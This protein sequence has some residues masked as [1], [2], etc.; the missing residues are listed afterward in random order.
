MVHNPGRVI[1]LLPKKL[2]ALFRSDVEGFYFSMGMMSGL[3]G[4][5]QALYVCLRGFAELYYIVL[6]VL[7]AIALPRVLPGPIQP[8]HIG[9]AVIVGLALVYLVLFG[10]SRYHFPMMTWVAMYSGLGAQALLNG[11][12]SVEL[13]GA[14][15]FARGSEEHLVNA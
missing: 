6:L 14:R 11:N 2:F 15:R 5:T 10:N 7:C 8:R 9:V 12:K 3:Q 1:M 13:D 4:L